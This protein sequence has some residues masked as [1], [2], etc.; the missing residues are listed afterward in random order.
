MNLT[1]A[2]GRYHVR[3]KLAAAR[4]SET[5]RSVLDIRVNGERVVER[6]GVSATAGGPDRAMDLVFN[7]VLPRDGIIE[8]R[9]T[10][11]PGPGGAPG[12]G[13]DAFIQALEVG[14]GRSKP[15]AR[16]ISALAPAGSPG[17][18]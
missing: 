14:P 13:G 6:L 1:V 12:E 2:P 11:A 8:V 9:F 3:L 17:L 18:R 5:S 7:D 15:G 10:A 4:G 16:A